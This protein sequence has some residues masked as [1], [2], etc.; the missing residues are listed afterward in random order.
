MT[1]K[2]ADYKEKACVHGKDCTELV[3][4]AKAVYGR[5]AEVL[6]ALRVATGI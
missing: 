1:M 6:T 2:C 5:D 3:E 4:E